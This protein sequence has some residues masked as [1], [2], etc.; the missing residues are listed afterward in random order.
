MENMT[1]RGPVV[2]GVMGTV[3]STAAAFFGGW[4]TALQ[5]LILLMLADYMTGLIVAGVFKR[6]T[7]TETGALESRAGLKG[8][9]RKGAALLVILIACRLDM[10]AGTHFVRDTAVMA[11]C[12]NEMLSIVENAGLMG[13]PIPTAVTKAIDIL[14]KKTEKE[15]GGE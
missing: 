15:N 11:Y 3:F 8:L 4:D 13:V 1:V 14:K 5:T 9:S 2:L 10:L 12:I 7:K 6:S